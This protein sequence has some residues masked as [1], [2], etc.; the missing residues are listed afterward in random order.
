MLIFNTEI[1]EKFFCIR[2]N[3]IYGLSLFLKIIT[4]FKIFI[5]MVILCIIFIIFIITDFI[6][7]ILDITAC[8]THFF[9]M[10]HFLAFLAF[11]KICWAFFSLV[12]TSTEKAVSYLLLILTIFLLFRYFTYF[13]FLSIPVFLL[14]F[15][16]FII[17]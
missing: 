10:I 17:S 9:K 4:E 2:N 7:I 1:Y 8:A 16:G 14:H 13:L 11:V 12:F 3:L 5:G 6:Y 15:P